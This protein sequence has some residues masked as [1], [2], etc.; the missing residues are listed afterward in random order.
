[1]FTAFVRRLVRSVKKS[2]AEVP[3]D[4]E[5][6]DVLFEESSAEQQLIARQEEDLQ[7]SYLKEVINGLPPR[8][9][10]LIFLK[11]YDGLSYEE[12]AVR[13]GLSIQSV[14][15]Q[16]STAIFTL[17][18]NDRLKKMHDRTGKFGFIFAFPAFF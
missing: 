2:E 11:Y 1:M 7:Q 18:K 10:E 14:Y 4:M 12:I 8:Q 9:R 13:T 6:L 5:Y 16:V 3:L 15:N 17:R